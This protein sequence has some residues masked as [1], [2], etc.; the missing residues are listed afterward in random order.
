MMVEENKE[1]ARKLK[2]VE[3]G[4]NIMVRLKDS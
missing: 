2:L 3:L 1:S 4:M